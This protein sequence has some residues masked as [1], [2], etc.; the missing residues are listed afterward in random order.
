MKKLINSY[1]HKKKYFSSNPKVFFLK[2]PLS[3]YLDLNYYI[4]QDDNSFSNQFRKLLYSKEVINKFFSIKTLQSNGQKIFDLNSFERT[5]FTSYHKNTL[6]KKSEI[7]FNNNKAVIIENHNHNHNKIVMKDKNNNNFFLFISSNNTFDPTRLSLSKIN[8]NLYCKEI[9]FDKITYI[10][11]I[12]KIENSLKNNEIEYS[13]TSFYSSFNKVIVELNPNIISLLQKNDISFI[14]KVF[15]EYRPITNVNNLIINSDFF[16]IINCSYYYYKNSSLTS[17]ISNYYL[18]LFELMESLKN[19]RK[20]KLNLITLNLS[21]SK[22][23]LNFEKKL[24]T[25]FF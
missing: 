11:S 13:I 23:N 18:E 9:S 6:M 14:E 8:N 17:I 2:D 22:I 10:E 12:L 1:K 24:K 5:I 21:L 19:N 25:Y 3:S 20:S 16:N 4:N 7:L 15:F